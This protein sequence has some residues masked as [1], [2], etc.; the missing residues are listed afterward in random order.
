[1]TGNQGPAASGPAL[2]R[3][4][5]PAAPASRAAPGA[6]EA[7][8]AA[9]AGTGAESSGPTSG[10]AAATP[11]GPVSGPP[12]W[13]DLHQARLQAAGQGHFADAQ[14]HWLAALRLSES[15]VPTDTRRLT[16]LSAL[17]VVNLSQRKLADAEV[18]ARRALA[19]AE[20]D[21]PHCPIDLATNCK[22]LAEALC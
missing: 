13:E 16:S 2:E 7:R 14:T 11:A 1:E 8:P 21:F 18:C 3:A 12:T 15:F 5:L 17:T 20:R 4:P 19:V 6:H 22:N 9:P 10:T